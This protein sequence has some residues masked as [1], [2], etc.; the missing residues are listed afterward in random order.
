MYRIQWNQKVRATLGTVGTTLHHGLAL[1]GL[2]AVVFVV[3]Q[4]ALGLPEHAGRA[5][6]QGSIRYDGE[7]LIERAEDVKHSA[8][9]SYVSRR[10][11]IASSATEQLVDA[12]YDAG[13]Q[14]GLDPLL[15]LAVMAIESRFNP[16]AESGMG[17]KG[18]MQVIPKH[19]QDK[20]ND[21]GG[22]IAVLDPT[23]NI[24]VGARILKEYIRRTGSLEAGLQFYN[25]ALA[26]I[27]S[28]YA[29]KVIAEMERL[30]E[31]QRGV[32]RRQVARNSA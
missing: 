23:T 26:D 24:L 12:A 30:Q 22:E 29:Q 3:M 14:V 17:A 28:Q 10:Y 32:D 27:S 8:L 6:A 31:A 11:R 7:S 21:H 18:L 19:H 2:A 9:V 5:A 15:I 20:L 1:I 13:Q 25:G 4:S 16:I